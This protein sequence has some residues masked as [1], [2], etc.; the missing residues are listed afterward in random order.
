MKIRKINERMDETKLSPIEVF[1][2][3]NLFKSVKSDY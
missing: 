3:S 1:A 2:L